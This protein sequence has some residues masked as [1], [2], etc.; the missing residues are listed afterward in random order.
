MA[1]L[2]RATRPAF[3]AAA[4]IAACAGLLAQAREARAGSCCGETSTPN[5]HLAEGEAAAISGIF[6]FRHRIGGFDSGG[7]FSTGG[8]SEERLALDVAASARLRPG[9]ELGL[10][11]PFVAAFKSSATEDDA[12][13]GLGDLFANVTFLVADGTVHRY[14]PSVYGTVGVAV[15]TGRSPNMARG[16]LAADALGQGAAELRASVLIEKTWSETWWASLDTMV[17]VFAPE[18]AR[19]SHIAR[20]PRIR[21]ATATGPVIGPVDIGLGVTLEVEPSASIDEISGA[22][23]RR[24]LTT[25][26]IATLDVSRRVRLSARIDLQPPASGPSQNEIAYVSASAGV[27][28]AFPED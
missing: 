26:A 12:A 10:S 23:S 5:G 28:V 19:G 13:F 21:A 9:L 20:A 14:L 17:G 24:L 27:R 15:P 4:S 2:A 25:S 8:L 11:A 18:S 16:R 1:V 22:S 7:A 3:R 6:T